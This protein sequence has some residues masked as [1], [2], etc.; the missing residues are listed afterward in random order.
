MS[1]GICPPRIVCAFAATLLTAASIGSATAADPLVPGV[2]EELSPEIRLV[3]AAITDDASDPLGLQVDEAIKITSRRFLTA[4][5]HTPWQILHGILALRQDFQIKLEG[6]KTSALKWLSEGNEW[7]DES[8]VVKTPHGGEFHRFTKPYHFQGHPN[9]FLAILTM[10]ELGTDYEMLTSKGETVTIEQMLNNAKMTVN[11]REEITWT[12]WSLA[13]YLS[14]D[15]EWINKDGEAWSME[16]LV[17]IQTY[18]DLSHAACGGTH[19]LFALSLARNSY[20]YSGKKPRGIWLEADQK[21]K[22]YIAEARSLQ[23]TD[24]TF[25]SNYF[26]GPGKS[27]D[28]GKRIATSGHILEFL[29]VAV[30]DKELEKPW[31]R[32]AVGAVANEL[33]E[34]RRK[35]AD[36]GP[37]YHALHALVLYR[38]RT[39]GAEAVEIKAQPEATKP[40]ATKP[41]ATKPEATKPEATTPESTTP[42]K[43]EASPAKT[44]PDTGGTKAKDAATGNATTEEAATREA[45]EPVIQESPEK[46]TDET[47]REEP[48]EEERPASLSD[49][50]KPQVKESVE[51]ADDEFVLPLFGGPLPATE[52][53]EE[54][55]ESAGDTTEKPAPKPVDPFAEE[56]AES[57][58]QPTTD[59]ASAEEESETEVLE[60]NARNSRG[61]SGEQPEAVDVPLPPTSD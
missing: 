5:V 52:P 37:L 19:G 15:S 22:R 28:F 51:P 30:D 39:G 45:K 27:E 2:P 7:K 23:N 56:P 47:P 48:V 58:A 26:A 25:S 16:R 14:I 10:S 43:P 41:E 35:A 49:E 57:A 33:T 8:V 60:D 18:A 29:M 34:N 12:L 44:D 17:Q 50:V 42:V 38:Q 1:L 31:L 36:C 24:G 4:N 55:E 6:Q 59:S 3:A 53:S 32:K 11:D 61:M 20:I 46:A 54:T 40:E 9:Q 21:I 13:R